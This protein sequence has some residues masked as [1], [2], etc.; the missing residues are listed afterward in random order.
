MSDNTRRWPS[1]MVD[2]ETLGTSA[3]AAVIELGAVC[4]D[5]ATGTMGP[6][7]GTKISLKANELAGRRIEAD[8]LGWWMGR[9]RDSG[10]VPDLSEGNTVEGAWWDFEE[11]WKANAEAA[12]EFWSRGSFDEVILRDL[13]EPLGGVPGRCW[14]VRD[15]RTGMGWVKLRRHGEPGHTAVE[16]AVDQVQSLFGAR[17]AL[18]PSTLNPQLSTLP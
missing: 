12:A 10:E 2:L 9:W 18:E 1:V 16:D 3:N 14:N 13:A 11:F 4:F 8:T 15:Q 5:L 17:R 7:F 6:R